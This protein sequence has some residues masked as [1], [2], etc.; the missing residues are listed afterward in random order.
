MKRLGILIVGVGGHGVVSAARIIGDAA[1]LEGIPVVVGQLHGL[2]QR[3]GSVQATV[4]LGPGRSA[5]LPRKGADVLLALEPFEAAR[6]IGAVG[7]QTTVL[8]NI[9]PRIPPTARSD[10]QRPPVAKL[11]SG[12]EARAA[13]LIAFDATALAQKAGSERAVNVVML[14]A[15]LGAG[16]V[17][18]DPER[19]VTSVA[20]DSPPATKDQNLA[21]FRLGRELAARYCPAR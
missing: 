13:R 4:L 9:V 20:A 3:G 11:L 16:C 8:T 2:A 19:F 18:L 12:L 5:I 17:P 7:T 10:T 6:A 21:A 1:H 14:G 15:L